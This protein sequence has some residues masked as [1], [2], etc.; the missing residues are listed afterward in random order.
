MFGRQQAAR[1]FPA[2][3]EAQGRERDI[4][5][6]TVDAEVMAIHGL[7]TALETLPPESVKRVLDY[8]NARFAPRYEFQEGGE[9]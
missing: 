3:I 1:Q 6:L 5:P 7:V 9:S 2:M 4:D 8:A